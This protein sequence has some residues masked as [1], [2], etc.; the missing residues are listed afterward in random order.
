M[1]SIS[2]SRPSPTP[3]GSSSTSLTPSTLDP[4][5]DTTLDNNPANSLYFDSSLCR[6]WNLDFFKDVLR[7][8]RPSMSDGEIFSYWKYK[9]RAIVATRTDEAHHHAKCLLGARMLRAGRR[10]R[11]TTNL[12]QVIIFQLPLWSWPSFSFL[13]LIA[14]PP[15]STYPP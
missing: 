14:P 6:I 12:N 7:E 5:V 4:P 15:P 3:S 11:S 1:S 2:S 10:P 8:Q 9:L 13:L